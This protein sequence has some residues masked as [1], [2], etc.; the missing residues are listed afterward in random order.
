MGE[1]IA[2][3]LRIKTSTDFWSS[4]VS[5]RFDAGRGGHT[6]M[7]VYHARCAEPCLLGQNL[8][9]YI[10][11]VIQFNMSVLSEIKWVS[12]LFLPRS[13]CF[14]LVPRPENLPL[15]IYLKNTM[16]VLGFS[17]ILLHWFRIN[18]G[19][20]R[21]PSCSPGLAKMN[22]VSS[23]QNAVPPDVMLPAYV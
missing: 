18:I 7:N 2:Q 15:A 3:K 20:A 5:R 11:R 16:P 4:S 22:R 21:N 19:R 1:N 17:P 13:R 10:L 8:F 9:R 14:M 12:L 6:G 23:F